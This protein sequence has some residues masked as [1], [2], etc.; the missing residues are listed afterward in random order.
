MQKKLLL[1]GVFFTAIL[2]TNTTQAQKAID[3]SGNIV[4]KEIPVKPFDALS[5]GGVFNVILQQGSSE[6]VKIEAEDNIQPLFIVS[7]EGS[8][9]S[10]K[11]Q[12]DI[13]L[14]HTKKMNVYVT[15]KSLKSLNIASVGNVTAKGTLSFSDL[16][17]ENNSVGSV[18]LDLSAQKISVKN[19]SVGSLK[20]SGKADNAIIRSN[21]VG[22]IQA[23]DFVVQT[24]DIQN[25]GVGGAEV[26]A[27]KELKVKDSFLGKVKNNGSAPTKKVSKQVI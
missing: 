2:F 16:S 19:N 6:Q 9:L 1:A 23:S 17:L 10:I 14:R 7:N 25:D 22:A 15:F 8:T 3:G 21:S 4:T 24:M 26:N 18:D 5:A 27:V 13:N 20:L 11:M 12:K